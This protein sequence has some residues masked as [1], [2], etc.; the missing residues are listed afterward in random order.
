MKECSIVRRGGASLNFKVVGG[1]SQ[2]ASPKE[3]DIWVNTDTA[4]SEW[5]FS[6]EQPTE[7][8]E[9]MVWFQTAMKSNAPFNALKKNSLVIYPVKCHQYVSGAWVNET[10]KTYQDGAWANWE[11]IVFKDGVWNGSY[12]FKNLTSGGYPPTYLYNDT[13]PVKFGRDSVGGGSGA[14]IE[15][16]DV[17]NYSTL[18]LT[19]EVGDDPHYMYYGMSSDTKWYDRSATNMVAYK[20][21][22]PANDTK[23]TV[24]ID[25]S[26]VSGS[27]YFKVY[28]YSLV[29]WSFSMY[30]LR[31]E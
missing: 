14:Y 22:L 19:F 6:A 9:G 16:I 7:P 27:F 26:A 15:G 24:T 13:N 31:F 20:N 5:V 8:V 18:H 4:I 3:N 1:T 11:L 21:T 2:P 10:A 29:A 30:E 23:T 28:G 17:T 12:R 25:I